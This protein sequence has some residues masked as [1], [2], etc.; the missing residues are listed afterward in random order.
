M[1]FSSA[2]GSFLIGICGHFNRRDLY[3]AGYQTLGYGLILWRQ[4]IDFVLAA[5]RLLFG[6]EL[7]GVVA[8]IQYGF[9]LAVCD[10]HDYRPHDEPPAQ[11]AAKNLGCDFGRRNLL[12]AAF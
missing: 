1:D 9:V 12:C 10:V 5:L 3:F 6:L 2:V 11:M 8:S 4:F 7:G